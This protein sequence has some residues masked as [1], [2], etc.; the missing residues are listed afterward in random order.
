MR[1]RDLER[2]GGGAKEDVSELQQRFINM[3]N[4]YRLLDAE[5]KSMAKYRT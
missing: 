5:R 2:G 1:V 4:M 3:V